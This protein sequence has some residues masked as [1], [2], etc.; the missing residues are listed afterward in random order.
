MHDR[1][2]S[3][4]RIVARIQAF[5][6]VAALALTLAL[7]G[8][9]LGGSEMAWAAFTA[10]VGLFW[11]QPLMAPQLMIKI[12]GGRPLGPS[13]APGLHQVLHALARKA[14]LARSPQLF[15]LPSNM[16]NAFTIGNREHAVVGVSDGLLRH[17][18][19]DEVAAVLAHEIAHIVNNDTRVMGFAALLSQLIQ[20]MSLVGQLLLTV[21]LPLI[22]AGQPILDLGGILVL[23]LTPYVGLL[24]QLALSRSREYLADTEAVALIGSPRPLATALARIE[25]H[26]HGLQRYPWRWPGIKPAGNMLL[27]THPPAPERIR[28]LLELQDERQLPSRHPARSSSRPTVFGHPGTRPRMAPCRLYGLCP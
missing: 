20:G 8:W 25:Q 7:A 24:L 11:L 15:Y 14:G 27:R 21:S 18:E 13:E 10:V 28:R 6:L 23:I 1:N 19:H 3:I 16:M 22:L 9:L 4:R 5:V 26:N 17:L 12:L 2:I